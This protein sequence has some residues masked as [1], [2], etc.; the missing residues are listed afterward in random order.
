[1]TG[2]RLSHYSIQEKLGAGGMGVVYRARDEMLSRDVALKVLPPGTQADETA[3]ARLLNE[4]RAA[5]ALN[6]PHICTIYEVAEQDAQAYIAME[7]VRGQPLSAMIPA[8][9]LPA[10]TVLH[11]G[12]QVADAMAH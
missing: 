4:A 8:H 12:T 5:S 2:Q 7:Y 10:E 6:H 3:R 9:G 11:F 1:M